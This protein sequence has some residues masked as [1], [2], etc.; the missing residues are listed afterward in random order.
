LALANGA[1][2]CVSASSDV[3]LM[4]KGILAAE[5]EKKAGAQAMKRGLDA[6]AKAA[7]GSSIGSGS[8]YKQQRSLQHA[9][10]VSVYWPLLV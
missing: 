7:G 3:K 10:E 4:L 6:A 5:T 8:A 2:A 1:T 9:Y